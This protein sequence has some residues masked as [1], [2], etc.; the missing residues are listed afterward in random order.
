VV[1]LEDCNAPMIGLE[2]DPP[3]T[4]DTAIGDSITVTATVT[5][6]VGSTFNFVANGAVTGAAVAV[7]KDPQVFTL[8]EAA[9]ATGKQRVRGEVDDAADGH[10]LTVTS[11]V[12]L[13]AAPPGCASPSS[14][15]APWA[16]LGVLLLVARRRA[17]SAT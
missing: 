6:G 2:T 5:H 8:T 3:R 17:R 11:Y 12:W 7:T 14:D 13:K 4:G 1:K 16:A 15:A 10:P 9:D